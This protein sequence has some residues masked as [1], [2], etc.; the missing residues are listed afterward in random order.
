MISKNNTPLLKSSL[1]ATYPGKIRTVFYSKVGFF[2]MKYI[3]GLLIVLFLT[4]PDCRAMAKENPAGRIQRLEGSAVI[5]REGKELIA[6]TNVKVF[7]S[8][9]ITTGPD[10]L[11]E[12]VLLDGSNLHMG[13]DSSLVLSR[14]LFGLVEDNPGFMCRMVK[15]IFVYISGTMSKL[16]PGSV[17]FE[18]PDGTVSIRGTKLVVRIIEPAPQLAVPGKTMIVLLKDPNGMVGQVSVS[19]SHGEKILQKEKHSITVTSDT[20]PS[21]QVFMNRETMEQM[22]P[23]ILHPPVFENYTPPLPYTEAVESQFELKNI[24]VKQTP[25]N[26]SIYY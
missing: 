10:S 9:E 20:P 2:H 3:I 7:Q 11:V 14:Y 5:V 26:P 18:T 22:I 6:R 25:N 17:Q 4:S 21:S 12:L 24:R 16:Y 15:G 23:I 19:N 1:S 8:D 13:P